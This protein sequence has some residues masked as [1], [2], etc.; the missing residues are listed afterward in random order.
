VSEKDC[1]IY[2]IATRNDENLPDKPVKVGIA[3]DPMKRLASLQTGNPRILDLPFTFLI[4]ARE[5]AAYFEKAFHHLQADRCVNGEW[6]DIHPI[7]AAQI[8]ALYLEAYFSMQPFSEEEIEAF[9]ELT[10]INRVKG[11]GLITN[12]KDAHG[13]NPLN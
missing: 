11:L 8:V 6:F 7:E 9:R 12:P 4:P 3:G 2:V 5:I 10:G 13:K 1:Y